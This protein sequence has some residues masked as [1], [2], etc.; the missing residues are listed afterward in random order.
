MNSDLNTLYDE[1]PQLK[2]K[3]MIDFINGIE[4]NDDLIRLRKDVNSGVKSRIWQDM[5]GE[6]HDRQ[7]QIDQNFQAGLYATSKWL[8]VIESN[9]IKSDLVIERVCFKLAETRQGVMKLKSAHLELKGQVESLFNRFDLLGDKFSK[10]ESKLHECDSGR[11]ATQQMEAVFDKWMAGGFNAYPWLVRL[12]LVL[13]ELYWGDFGFFCRQFTD[14]NI[15]IERLL[16]QV[17][18]KSIINLKE[19]MRVVGMLPEQVFSWQEELEKGVKSLNVD[20]INAL[21]LLTDYGDER[22]TPISWVFH[23]YLANQ[24]IGNSSIDSVPYIFNAE[25]I[26]EHMARNFKGRGAYER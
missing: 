26:V 8:Q 16:E 4:V 12:Y 23:R 18:N 25:N 19:D 22:S 3:V 5:T 20:R 1:I 13:D 2:E 21:A 15:E 24:T 17:K 14:N 9:Q 7:Q 10:L 11:L 6:T